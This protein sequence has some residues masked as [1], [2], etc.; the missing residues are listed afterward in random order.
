MKLFYTESKVI[1]DD[2]ILKKW[3][4]PPEESI[5]ELTQRISTLEIPSSKESTQ[6]KIYATIELRA[7][8]SM[9]YHKRQTYR[10]IEYLGDIGGLIQLIWICGSFFVG[11]IIEREFKAAMV[12]ETY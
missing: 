6:E 9:R 11:F 4:P 2:Y 12:S 8:N 1:L 5:F 7:D 10:L 3:L